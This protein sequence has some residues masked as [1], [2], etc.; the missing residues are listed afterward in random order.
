MV[1]RRRRRRRR[2]YIAV[3]DHI[4]GIYCRCVIKGPK[5]EAH[6]KDEITERGQVDYIS[7]FLFEKRL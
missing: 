6:H 1:R 3:V 5:E 2:L 4:S 7:G